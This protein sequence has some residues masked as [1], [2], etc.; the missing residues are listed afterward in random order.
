MCVNIEKTLGNETVVGGGFEDGGSRK[1]CLCTLVVQIICV[2]L[3]IPLC[4]QDTVDARIFAKDLVARSLLNERG[5][6]Y[7]VHGLLLS[8]AKRRIGDFEEIKDVATV[9][10]AEYLG[11]LDTLRGF[12]DEE[13]GSAGFYPLI[14]LWKSLEELSGDEAL[15]SKTYSASLAN[16]LKGSGDED[17]DIAKDSSAVARLLELQVGYGKLLKYYTLFVCAVHND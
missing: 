10:Q 6:D 9:R 3:T 16:K 2:P 15:E 13:P 8:F 12:A 1:T 7:V 11:N 5:V 4:W 14:S 17:L